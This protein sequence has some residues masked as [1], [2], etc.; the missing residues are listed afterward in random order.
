MAERLGWVGQPDQRGTSDIIWSC[1]LAL[2]ICLWAM[3]HLNVPAR[4]ESQWSWICRKARHMLLGAVLPEIPSS[5]AIGQWASARRSVADMKAAGHEGWTMVH[6]FYVEMGGFL[7]QTTQQPS[8]PPFP[9]SPKQ[10]QYLLDHGY[11]GRPSITKKEI[12]DKSK[13]DTVIKLFAFVQILWLIMQNIAR[14]ALNMPVST[15]ELSTMGTV[16]ASLVSMAAWFSKPLD[17]SEP[18]IL[19]ANTSISDILSKAQASAKEPYKNVPLDF[20]E[21]RDHIGMLYTRIFHIDMVTKQRPLP[22]LPN[23]PDMWFDNY[24]TVSLTAAPF[25]ILSG[26]LMIGWN[27]S[28]PTST[29][30][31]IWRV[32]SLTYITSLAIWGAMEIAFLMHDR[33]KSTWL[34]VM[35]GYKQKWPQCL[36]YHVPINISIVARLIIAGL[37]VAELRSLPAGCYENIEWT[38]FIPHL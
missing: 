13:A 36:L 32:A 33:Y 12:L 21:K 15:L 6:A 38:S 14:A 11:V 30:K 10:F 29:E 3:L 5:V 20:I 17:V 9:I 28:F 16:T 23:E 34:G 7:L 19:V 1:V 37:C 4:S 22:R 26:I 24:F 2:F 8:F 27:F 25:A 35:G 31:T 18:T